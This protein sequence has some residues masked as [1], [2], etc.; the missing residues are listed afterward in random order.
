MN[1]IIVF[2]LAI[3][4]CTVSV[5]EWRDG[6]RCQEREEFDLITCAGEGDVIHHLIT[7]KD[8][9]RLVVSG[10]VGVID[11]INAPSISTIDLQDIDL[12]CGDVIGFSNEITIYSPTQSAIHCHVSIEL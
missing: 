7:S 11:L 10:V 8:V 3:V 12:T 2:I 9:Y 6:G 1:L 5:V 4:G